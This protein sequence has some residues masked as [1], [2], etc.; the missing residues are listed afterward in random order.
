MQTKLIKSGTHIGYKTSMWNPKMSQYIHEEREDIHLIDLNKTE[1]QITIARSE[2]ERI[3]SKGRNI[4]FVGTKEQAKNPLEKFASGLNM[5]YVTERWTGG[6][7]TNFMTTKKSI[8]KMTD[9]EKEMNNENKTKKERL[10]MYRIFNKLKRNFGGILNMKR[11][12]AAI[13][14]VDPVHE[15]LAL[16]EAKK[17]GIPVIAICDT[18]A[19]PDN[20]DIVI[21]A[22]ACSEKSLSMIFEILLP[23]SETKQMETNIIENV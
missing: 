1:T 21:P 16:A 3:L 14:I 10:V 20:I 22:N 13:F 17:L 4:L 5:P 6:I 7:L 11:L 9:T 18:N 23:V 8:K 2:I 19:N 15:H 12:P